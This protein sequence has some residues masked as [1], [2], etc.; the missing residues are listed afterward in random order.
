M[1][2]KQRIKR[3]SLNC[4]VYIWVLPDSQS[5]WRASPQKKKKKP[6][7]FLAQVMY[8]LWVFAVTGTPDFTCV[9]PHTR[10]RFSLCTYGLLHICTTAWV[11]LS[12]FYYVISVITCSPLETSCG[13]LCTATSLMKYLTGLISCSMFNPFRSTQFRQERQSGKKRWTENLLDA[14]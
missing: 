4:S 7:T 13:F 2:L 3:N 5:S 11:S 10:L 9:F 12:S 8:S 1:H 14:N 6:T